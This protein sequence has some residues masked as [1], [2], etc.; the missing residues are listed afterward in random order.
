MNFTAIRKNDDETIIA[1][2]NC[3]DTTQFS[4]SEGFLKHLKLAVKQWCE[5]NEEGKKM[6]EYSCG[7][8]NFGDLATVFDNPELRNV[9]AMHGIIN[10]SITITQ[11]GSNDFNYD[12][13]LI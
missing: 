12:T 7:D 9:L 6:A 10:L 11:V 4:N 13:V 8:F 1:I 2:I 3:N 5:H